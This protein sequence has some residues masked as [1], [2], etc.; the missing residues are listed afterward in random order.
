MNGCTFVDLAKRHFAYLVRDFG[1]SVVDEWMNPRSFGNSLVAYRSGSVEIHVK[2]DRGDVLID[3]GPYPSPGC[4]YEFGLGS[5][6][7]FLKLDLA[8]PVY[9]FPETWAS[10]CEHNEDQLVRVARV[11]REYF[12]PVLRG[13]F[14]DWEALHGQLKRDGMAEYERLTGKK[15]VVLSKE[16]SD[17]IRREE[18]CRIEKAEGDREGSGSSS[19]SGRVG[20]L[21]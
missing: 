15:P 19:V 21:R 13:E 4:D 20:Q 10:E 14:R 16:Q 2:R 6:A 12:A 11:L 18:L 1:Y 9:L 8:E 7:G 3:V 5:V 17:G